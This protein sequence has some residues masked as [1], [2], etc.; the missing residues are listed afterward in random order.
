VREVRWTPIHNN[1]CAL[2]GALIRL[3]DAVPPAM[4][5]WAWAGRVLP[6]GVQPLPRLAT[7]VGGE[8]VPLH[9]S[10]G[11]DLDGLFL[12]CHSQSR[13]LPGPGA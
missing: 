5:A 3:R 10:M 4:S 2:A 9:A 11:V 13:F 6:V 7:L 1:A 8:V 12:L